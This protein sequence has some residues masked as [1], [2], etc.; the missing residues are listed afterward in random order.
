MA[1]NP[2]CDIFPDIWQPVPPKDD[3]SHESVILANEANGKVYRAAR[4]VVVTD[5][6]PGLNLPEAPED[7][8]G[9]PN[10]LTD[11]Q[12]AM[13]ATVQ[14]ILVSD[15]WEPTM[16]KILQASGDQ[17]VDLGGG[18]SMVIDARFVAAVVAAV[19]EYTTQA[20]LFNSTFD[21]LKAESVQAAATTP[22]PSKSKHTGATTSP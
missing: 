10:Q 9:N 18:K 14:G 21:Q 8:P 16:G 11:Q 15:D 20:P 12:I 1:H 4:H 22:A 6:N 3:P 17:S 7:F 13:M 5:F 19:Q 2:A